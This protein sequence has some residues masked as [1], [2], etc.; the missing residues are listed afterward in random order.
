MRHRSKVIF[1]G[2]RTLEWYET[3]PWR[4]AKAFSMKIIKY[5]IQER[6]D[7]SKTNCRSSVTITKFLTN[8]NITLARY[9]FA[10]TITWSCFVALKNY[11]KY[12]H[13]VVHGVVNIP[14]VLYCYYS[15]LDFWIP[16]EHNLENNQTNQ[17]IQSIR[18][19]FKCFQSIEFLCENLKSAIWRH[20]KC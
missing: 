19:T 9:C 13:G 14:V 3:R 11:F 12:V 1:H 2:V 5:V 20:L 7:R 18:D 16:E 4:W 17:T 8:T 6:R 15:T 10:H